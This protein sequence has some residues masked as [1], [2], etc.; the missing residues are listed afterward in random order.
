MTYD[1][2][3]TKRLRLFILIYKGLKNQVKKKE[4]QRSLIPNAYGVNVLKNASKNILIYFLS[5]TDAVRMYHEKGED[6]TCLEL[7]EN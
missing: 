3:F 4:D 6:F 5:V 2:V 7:E 1:K